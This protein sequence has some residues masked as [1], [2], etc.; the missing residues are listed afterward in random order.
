MVRFFCRFRKKLSTKLA[1][2]V[3]ITI[4][5]LSFF[6][7]HC[8]TNVN[9]DA[10]MD[11]Y[12]ENQSLLRTLN[13]YRILFLLKLN[14]EAILKSDINTNLTMDY[15][16]EHVINTLS[17]EDN[18]L[19]FKSSELFEIFKNYIDRSNISYDTNITRF[20]LDIINYDGIQ[21]KKDGNIMITIDKEKLKQFLIKRSI[22]LDNGLINDLNNDNNDINNNSWV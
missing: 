21:K 5:L 13:T 10:A 9:R 4:F 22:N 20:G 14:T 7:L 11:I 12:D 8:R 16:L 1:L 6:I 2:A 15:F 17:K 3:L 18:T 19:K